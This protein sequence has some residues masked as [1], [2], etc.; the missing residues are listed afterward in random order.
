MQH[1]RIRFATVPVGTTGV[2]ARPIYKTKPFL[3]KKRR[4]VTFKT[5][6]QLRAHDD[7]DEELE[8]CL[9]EECLCIFSDEEPQSDASISSPVSSASDT[10]NDI[11][12]F[13]TDLQRQERLHERLQKYE[14]KCKRH[15]P[16]SG[17][18]AHPVRWQ[19]RKRLQSVIPREVSCGEVPVYLSPVTAVTLC[20]RPS[21]LNTCHQILPL[22][23]SSEVYLSPRYEAW[24]VLRLQNPAY[25]Y[26]QLVRNCLVAFGLQW[27]TLS[28]IEAEA[29]K[30]GMLTPLDTQVMQ[31]SRYGTSD[32]QDSEA[33]GHYFPYFEMG[34]TF[35]NKS[36]QRAYMWRVAPEFVKL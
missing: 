31:C 9:D 12:R 1:P 30:L 11:Q 5:P 33:W 17:V 28:L 10:Q 34:Y 22:H 25:T 20:S 18:V 8:S 2:T 16:A 7:D 26:H 36:P 19:F 13:Q 27:V 35:T 3:L 14:C 21:G 23:L 6:V 15:A 4:I 32:R 24:C 29:A